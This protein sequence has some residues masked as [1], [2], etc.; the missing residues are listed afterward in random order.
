MAYTYNNFNVTF[1]SQYVAQVEIDRPK[2]LNA[3]FEQMWKD[4]AKIFRELSHDPEV[5]VV[6]L[7][8]AGDRA[9]TA[10]LDV[11]AA[12]ENGTLAKT[13]PILDGARK[14]VA[15]RRHILEFQ[16]DITEIEKCEKPVIAVLHGV[17]YGLAIDMT[18]CCD[19]RI[20]SADTR[21][22]VREVDIGLAADIGTLTRLPK[23]NV[24]MSWVKEVALTARDFGAEEALRVGFVSAVYE[25]KAAALGR[26]LDMAKLL[27]SKSPVAVQTTKQMLN[28]SRD[29]TVA[30]G[31]AQIAVLNA[32]M[33]QTKDVEDAMLSGLKKHKPTFAKL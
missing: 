10:G 9:F 29:H 32:A 13:G 24:P 26:A 11:Q 2:K 5:R 21:F 3:F 14:A 16:D 27:A 18:T 17:S 31:L 6:I 33:L 15:L 28:Y 20:C 22:S 25:S 1:P 4:I 8:A 7:T 12:S 19:I 30:D 23:A